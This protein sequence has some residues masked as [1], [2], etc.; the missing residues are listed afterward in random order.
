VLLAASFEWLRELPS[1]AVDK[2]CHIVPP[3]GMHVSLAANVLLKLE[4]IR[5]F[6]THCKIKK[7]NLF[8]VYFDVGT[9]IASC[10][11]QELVQAEHKGSVTDNQAKNPSWG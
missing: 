8:L 11:G 5:L 3:Q 7:N 6:L 4:C 1:P 2:N 9:A 10:L